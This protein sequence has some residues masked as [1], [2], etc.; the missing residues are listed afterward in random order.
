MLS[1]FAFFLYTYYSFLV[2]MFL[3]EKHVSPKLWLCLYC[4]LLAGLSLFLANPGTAFL[5]YIFSRHS[6]TLH[7]S[8]GTTFILLSFYQQRFH[9]AK[10]SPALFSFP[11]VSLST[12]FILHSFFPG[13]LSLC[14][15]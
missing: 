15:V 6:L 9:C 10:F 14:F 12:A 2:Q 8:S 13:Q 1:S 5:F 11:I 7:N 3:Y 4:F